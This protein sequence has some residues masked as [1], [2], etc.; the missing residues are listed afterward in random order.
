MELHHHA[1]ELSEVENA[2]PLIFK[3]PGA[4]GYRLH[5]DIPLGWKGFPQSFLTV[6]IPIDALSRENG[7]TEVFAGY[8][9]GHLSQNSTEYMLPDELVEET[10][11]VPLE[12][13]PGDIAVFH[14]LTPHR[15][16][17]NR[18]S[19]MRRTLYVSYNALS[20]GGDQRAVHYEEFQTKMRQRLEAQSSESIFFK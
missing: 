16:A 10:R 5:Q 6:L 11:R 15:S 1:Q 7:C 20:E 4:T 14:G 8:H 9:S 12:L 3:P 18:S 19:G 17:P 2:H 13:E